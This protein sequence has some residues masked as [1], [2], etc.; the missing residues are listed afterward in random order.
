MIIHIDMDAYYASVE[1]RDNPHLADKPVVIG[2]SATGRG[3]VST[4]NYIARK[5]GVQ[6]AM[7][8]SQA[9]R[10]CPQAILIRP[11][12]DYYAA[13]SKQIRDIFHTY[14]DLV[15]PLSL[16]EAFLDVTGSQKLF[17]DAVTIAK[18]IKSRIAAEVGLTASAGVAPN[19]FLAKVASDLEKPD[20]MV[21]VHP[22][23]IQSFLDPLPVAR[24]WGVGAQTQKK[25]EAYGVHTIAHLR[26][27]SLEVL[28]SAFGINSDHFWRLSRGLDT[29]AVVP[30]RDAK[31]ISHETTFHRDLTDPD[32]LRAWLLDLTDQ[33]AR[34][35]RRYKIVGRT[36]Q[37]K[38]RYSNFETITRS[39][40]LDEPTNSTDTLARFASDL[41]SKSQ[42]NFSRGI[43][44]I[45][46]GVDKLSCNRPV[47]L[48]LFDQE[49][50]ERSRRIDK[51]T[52]E[53]RDKFGKLA[54]KR[55][56]TLRPKSNE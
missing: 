39:R 18:Q 27:L 55:G 12:M 29:R 8:T 33:V 25:L 35:M 22:D 49:D 20:G 14:T 45:G 17:G 28:K 34:R 7:A 16:D 46:M 43:R 13:I 37:L 5:F 47:Q 2:G 19:K 11:R 48:S 56:S 42:L 21:V 30:D 10:L 51:A 40:T 3:V 24:V 1:I 44:L 15:E 36:V 9:V 54:L 32:A 52:D 53:I 41:F 50:A 26:Q 6:S 4:A 31:S 23:S 38:I